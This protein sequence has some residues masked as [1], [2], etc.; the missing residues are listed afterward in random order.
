MKRTAGAL[1]LL[2]SLGGSV[3]VGQGMY[4][5]DKPSLRD[6]AMTCPG[7]LG[8][9]SARSARSVP[10]A[11]GP[12]GQPVPVAAPYTTTVPAGE[13]AARA[14][15][16]TSVP[17]DLVQQ[18]GYS[19]PVD[20]S[21]GIVRTQAPGGIPGAMPM[22]AG[23]SPLGVPAMPPVPGAPNGPPA[24][25]TGPGG[26]PMAPPPSPY[27]PGAVAAVGAITPGMAAPF[28]SA[29]TS[30]RFVEPS[31]MKVSWYT[32]GAPGKNGFA[33][34]SLDVPARYNF[35][36][37]AI[38]RL[39]LS[40]I[41][42]RP[43]LEL[44]PTLEVV[45]ANPKTATFLAH[46]AVPVVFTDEDFE[47]VAAGNL[48]V[49]VVYLPDPLFQDQAAFGP[50]EVVSTRLEP[51]VD[52]IMEAQKRGCILLV[53]RLGNIDLEAPNTPAMDA[54]SPF[55]PKMPPPPPPGMG[56][57]PGPM[58]PFGFR[59]PG[60]PMPPGA[61]GQGGPMMPPAGMMPRPMPPGAMPGG[62]PTGPV[63]GPGA[64]LPDPPASVRQAGF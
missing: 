23:I 54:P 28:C 33:A 3:A 26:A 18:A 64:R 1:V 27:P 13:A 15:L 61:M 63:P 25:R 2:A 35:L 17:L 20:A 9:F 14:M 24:V 53:V 29:R 41:P 21:S 58:V 48:V 44:Y 56:A 62:A 39:K 36:Q 38:Y 52:P 45:P 5:G 47:Q 4:L 34:A 40:D 50:N 43:G 46:S 37:G 57:A 42:N 12:W 31:G 55:A 32:P 49:K 16:A 6:S 30:V 22:P 19:Q 51:G 59:G 60:G 8:S 7:C 11:V 10:G